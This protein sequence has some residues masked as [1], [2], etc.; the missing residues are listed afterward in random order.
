MDFK[1]IGCLEH[2]G[3]ERHEL[4]VDM[5]FTKKLHEGNDAVLTFGTVTD[6]VESGSV[7][8]RICEHHGALQNRCGDVPIKAFDLANVAF[9]IEAQV[10]L[11][12]HDVGIGSR[13]HQPGFA[14]GMEWSWD[15]N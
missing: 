7:A 5:S 11:E 15:L 9:N 3:L 13:V 6:F 2:D 12:W 14:V 8:S 1:S 4:N 10:R